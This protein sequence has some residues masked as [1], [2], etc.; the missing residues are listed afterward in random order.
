MT[1]Y[2]RKSRGKTIN[3]TFFVFCEGKSEDSYISFLRS[4]YRLPIE[5][6]SKKAG[7]RLTQKYINNT[8]KPLPQHRKDRLFLMYDLDTSGMLEKLQGIGKATLLV[9]NPCFELWYILHFVSH[10]AETTTQQCV[11]KFQRLCKGYKKGYISLKLRER[12]EDSL[13]KSVARAKKLSLYKNPSTSIYL[14]IDE[15]EKI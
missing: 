9:S 10:T 3:P 7:N 2:R 14:L 1:K 13:D 8:L 11:E 6:F 5:I 15:L 12:L 4:R